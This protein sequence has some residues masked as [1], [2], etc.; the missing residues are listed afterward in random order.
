MLD[1]FH[2]HEMIYHLSLRY[3]PNICFEYVA[4]APFFDLISNLTKIRTCSGVASVDNW[5][6]KYS[7]TCV[8]RP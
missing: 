7:Y 3:F 8:N 2:Y 4:N 5:R 1:C 6:N